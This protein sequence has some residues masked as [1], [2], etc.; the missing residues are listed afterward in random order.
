MTATIIEMTT[1]TIALQD[2]MYTLQT[3]RPL[4]GDGELKIDQREV[5]MS[6]RSGGLGRG[7]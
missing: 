4:T 3:I 1:T 5:I 2:E 6:F 7:V